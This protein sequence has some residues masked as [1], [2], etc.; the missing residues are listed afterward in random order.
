MG[1]VLLVASLLAAPHLKVV[2]SF[3]RAVMAALVAAVG[4]EVG[5]AVGTWWEV[6]TDGALKL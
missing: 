2:T 3:C 4:V 5:V 1:T 6:E